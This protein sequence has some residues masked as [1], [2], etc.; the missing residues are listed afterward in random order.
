[1]QY[2]SENLNPVTMEPGRTKSPNIFMAS[3][4]DANDDFFDKCLEEAQL[5]L[6]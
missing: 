3:V 2:A 1:M 6:R 5:C 4:L